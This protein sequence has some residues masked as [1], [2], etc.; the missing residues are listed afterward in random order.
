M[1]KLLLTKT[2]SVKH[3]PPGHRPPHRPGGLCQED[4]VADGARV[5][6]IRGLPP[7]TRLRNGII[8]CSAMNVSNHM[9]YWYMITHSSRSGGSAILCW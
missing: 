8:L 3:L 6:E 2:N 1:F 4:D 7:L 5:R 9:M